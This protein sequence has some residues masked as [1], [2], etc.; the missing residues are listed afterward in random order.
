MKDL[1]LTVRRSIELLGLCAAFYVFSAGSGVIIPICLAFFISILLM[2]VFHFF[3]R[4]RFPE[5]MAIV[6]SIAMA[7]LVVAGIIYF[8]SFQV[9]QLISDIPQLK[10]NS[11]AHWQTLSAWI[12]SKTHFSSKQQLEALQSQVDNLAGNVGQYFQTAFSSI[13]SAFIFLGL[14]PIYTFLILFYRKLLLQFAYSWFSKQDHA[15]VTEA[16]VETQVITKSYLIGL[17]IQIGYITVLLG[18]LLLILGIKHALLIGIIFAILNLIPYIGALIGN[19]IGVAL[20]LASSTELKDMLTV[21]I[22]IAVVQFLDNNILMPRI[23]GSKVRINAL[24]SILGVVIGGAVAGI[25]GM[26]LSLPIIAVL[27]VMFDKTEGLNQWGILFGDERPDKTPLNK[28]LAQVVKEE[29][30]E[31]IKGSRQG[32]KHDIGQP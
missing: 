27:K 26:F 12:T 15:R 7:A 14:I 20:T 19:L 3:R 29:T 21:L 10:K 8:F 18:G 17:L 9:S 23:V 6:F 1:P 32:D 4:L 28:H 5:V 13:T 2:P 16:L 11:A 30:K 25:G 24:I 22:A 31:E